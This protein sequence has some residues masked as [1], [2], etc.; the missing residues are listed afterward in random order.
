MSSP[1]TKMIDFFVAPNRDRIKQNQKTK[2]DLQ[3]QF[4]R[5]FLT[6]IFSFSK[7]SQKRTY[8]KNIFQ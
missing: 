4:T 8:E 1:I 5:D 3:N 7:N 6:N 2:H